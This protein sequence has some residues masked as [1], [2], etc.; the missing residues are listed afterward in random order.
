MCTIIQRLESAL[1]ALSGINEE[2]KG[3][4]DL[5][6]ELMPIEN[7]IADVLEELKQQK[8]VNKKR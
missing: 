6:S 5:Y 8:A 3:K 7:D 1:E 4:S 2:L